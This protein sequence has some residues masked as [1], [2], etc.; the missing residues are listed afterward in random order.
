MSFSSRNQSH[1]QPFGQA[2]P[3]RSTFQALRKESPPS[4]V[5]PEPD[6][7]H[8]CGVPCSASQRHRRRPAA[9]C[10]ICGPGVC[11]H[12]ITIQAPACKPPVAQRLHRTIETA[13]HLV[14][15][16]SG[17]ASPRHIL[18]SATGVAWPR[19]RRHIRSP[20]LAH[21]P[22]RRTAEAGRETARRRKR[23]HVLLDNAII[24]SCE[25]EIGTTRA[26]KHRSKSNVQ[27]QCQELRSCAQ[28]APWMGPPI[29]WNISWVG[30]D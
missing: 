3:R 23:N 6:A 20:P 2:Q 30:L 12:I 24:A 26:H 10:H 21:L 17:R 7:A 9:T 27:L 1:V 8:R 28:V 22:P 4:A 29:L 5:P 16:L 15:S 11:S 19:D 18:C 25:K 14:A 13:L